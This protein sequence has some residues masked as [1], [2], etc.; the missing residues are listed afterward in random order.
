MIKVSAGWMLLWILIC[1]PIAF[2]YVLFA[3]DVEDKK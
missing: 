2:L 3:D 1:P